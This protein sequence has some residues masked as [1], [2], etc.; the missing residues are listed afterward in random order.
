MIASS[1]LI[2]LLIEAVSASVSCGGHNADSCRLCPNDHGEDW[3]HGECHWVNGDCVLG[4]SL[5]EE[6]TDNN[7]YNIAEPA[8]SKPTIPTTSDATMPT[9]LKPTMPT[10]SKPTVGCDEPGNTCADCGSERRAESC[11]VCGN[12]AL[13]CSGDCKWNEGTETCGWKSIYCG[14]EFKMTDDVMKSEDNSW[15]EKCRPHNTKQCSNHWR[16]TCA[17]CLFEVSTYEIDGPVKTKKEGEGWCDKKLAFCEWKNT[18]EDQ[19]EC[20]DIAPLTCKTGAGIT[21]PFC[22]ECEASEDACGSDECVYHAYTSQCIAKLTNK[23]RAATLHLKTFKDSNDVEIKKSTW[24]FQKMT[25]LAVAQSTYFS[26]RHKRGYGGIQ[27]MPPD[28]AKGETKDKGRLIF[29][30][31]DN[32]GKAWKGK[33]NPEKPS[34]CRADVIL[35]GTDVP[36]HGFEGEGEGVKVQFDIY[37]FPAVGQDYYVAIHASDGGKNR[38]LYT[39]YFYVDGKWKFLGQLKAGLS[40]TE[41]GDSDDFWIQEPQNFLEAWSYLETDLSRKASFGQP[42]MVGEDGNFVQTRKAEF[43]Y[44]ASK[45]RTWSREHIDAKVDATSNGIILEIGGDANQTVKNNFE[46]KLGE[47]EVV[48]SLYKSL[49][50]TIETCVDTRTDEITA[51]IIESCLDNIGGA[52]IPA[53]GETAG[54]EPERKGHADDG[55]YDRRFLRE[56]LRPAI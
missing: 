39:G 31:W 29:S 53:G 42:F 12:E 48:P 3:C 22:E 20:V 50:D 43:S 32:C 16:P 27:R 18:T 8:T 33:K 44:D 4:A 9:T 41:F 54:D 2:L 11:E 34:Y 5:K 7:S 30:I 17:D 46:F 24:I 52:E 13:L 47:A 26:L 15:L 6:D 36:T 38:A 35:S 28:T 19:G 1:F 37:D 23:T 55:S 40:D 45:S 10:T 21:K 51:V 49:K 56:P 14:I 25:P